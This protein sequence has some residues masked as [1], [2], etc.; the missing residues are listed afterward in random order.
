[1]SYLLSIAEKVRD[2]IVEAG[3]FTPDDIIINY[4]PSLDNEIKAKLNTLGIACVITRPVIRNS[5]TNDNPDNHTLAFSVEIGT[6]IATSTRSGAEVAEQI[7]KLIH[8][9]NPSQLGSDPYVPY[10]EIYATGMEQT[11][12]SILI[13]RVTFKCD[14]NI[15]I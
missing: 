13:N 5:P 15:Y 3:I 7:Y 6:N 14:Y 9:F 1:M 2:K 11:T 4:T 12:T 8:K 10:D